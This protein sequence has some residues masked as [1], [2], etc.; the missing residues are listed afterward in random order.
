MQQKRRIGEP[1]IASPWPTRPGRQ[2]RTF[3][4]NG[5]PLGCALLPDNWTIQNWS[6]PR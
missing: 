1:S 3:A 4:M 6:F 2:H 5:S